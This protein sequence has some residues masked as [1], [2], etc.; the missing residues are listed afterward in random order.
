VVSPPWNPATTPKH[1][2][3]RTSGRWRSASGGSCVRPF[4]RNTR[5]T[6]QDCPSA[7][8]RCA[9]RGRPS[10]AGKAHWVP[11]HR[12]PSASHTVHRHSSSLS[13]VRQ[14]LPRM[15][16]SENKGGWQDRGT[17]HRT[18]TAHR[19]TW[20]RGDAYQCLCQV[21]HPL[22]VPVLWSPMAAG[23]GKTQA[24][25]LILG[26]S[27]CV[28]VARIARGS[29]LADDHSFL[30]FILIKGTAEFEGLRGLLL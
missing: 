8:Q 25:I 4:L 1:G 21:S 6:R 28:S 3:L 7:E 23:R 5:Q 10:R 2:P 27:R 9:G 29:E 11:C 15:R 14:A 12:R 13:S 19:T 22:P 17:W 24:N 30:A 18:D 20:T 16:K 26:Q